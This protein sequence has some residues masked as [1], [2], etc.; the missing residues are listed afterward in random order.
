MRNSKE[1]CPWLVE[2]A[3]KGKKDDLVQAES[4]RYTFIHDV[5]DKLKDT[6]LICDQLANVLLAGR[7]T[8]ACLM[9]W[10]L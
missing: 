2:Q 6:S 5:Y 4:S 3:L 7:D 10:T 9:S 8:T 1:L